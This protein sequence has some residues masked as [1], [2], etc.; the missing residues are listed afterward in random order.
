[1][2]NRVVPLHR[3]LDT[4][5]EFAAQV[6]AA[7]PNAVARTKKLLDEVAVRGVGADLQMALRFHMEFRHEGEIREGVAAFLEKREPHWGPRD[8]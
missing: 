4:A 8:A 1:M 6:V 3:V 2:V 7:A 5:R